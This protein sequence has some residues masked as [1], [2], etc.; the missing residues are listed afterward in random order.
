MLAAIQSLGR[1]AFL[2]VEAQANRVFGERHN[3]FHHLGAISY[4]MFWLVVASGFYV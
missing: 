3:P 4:W 1:K 2:A